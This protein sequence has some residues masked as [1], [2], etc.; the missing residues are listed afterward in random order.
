MKIF[1][2]AAVLCG[3]AGMTAACAEPP[4]KPIPDASRNGV[5]AVSGDLQGIKISDTSKLGARGSDEGGRLGA[6]QGAAAVARG[7]N[8]LS[9]LMMP[10][11]AAVGGAKGAAEAQ[12]E[13]VVDETRANLRVA[14]QEV[15]FTELLRS[16]LTAFA[17]GEA[18]R[19]IDITSGSA[20]A[21]VMDK[22][23]KPIQQMLA[24]EYRLNI[25]GEYLVNP[26]IG[27]YVTITA[28]V[29]SPDRKQMIHKATW[30]YCGERQDFVQMAANNAAGL[31]AQIDNA[32]AIL[33]EAIPYDLYVSREPRRL[34]IKGACM[35]FTNLP[36]GIGK[37]PGPARS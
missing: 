18:P 34:S 19:I 23:G 8:L 32:A 10:V 22:D 3:I 4:V 2:T 30:S 29:Q 20:T 17:M 24:L 36:S 5:S 27:I 1:R 16:R 11:G 31:R 28:Q 9:L 35:D 15:D 6:T 25:Y 21:P 37:L 13:A 14:I 12:S 26:K 33:A 7:G